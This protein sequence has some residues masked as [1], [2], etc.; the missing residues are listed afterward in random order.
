MSRSRKSLQVGAMSVAITPSF[1][2]HATVQY[3]QG[4]VIHCVICLQILTWTT[5]LTTFIQSHRLP[6]QSM[7]TGVS[8]R[9]ADGGHELFRTM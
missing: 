6:F 4:I 8:L 2:G 1:T 3:E 9:M 7:M 5:L